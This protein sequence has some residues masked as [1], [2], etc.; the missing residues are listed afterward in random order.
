MKKL[1]KIHSESEIIHHF[2]SGKRRGWCRTAWGDKPSTQ[3]VT[4]MKGAYSVL[5]PD[6]IQKQDD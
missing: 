3:M 4:A 2:V 5:T 1:C 6:N